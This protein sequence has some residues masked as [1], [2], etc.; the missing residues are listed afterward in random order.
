M[1]SI[2]GRGRGM[3]EIDLRFD[4]PE[5]YSVWGRRVLHP[6]NRAFKPSWLFYQFST[7]AVILLLGS[8]LVYA[9]IIGRAGF[10]SLVAGG[11]IGDFITI[12]KFKVLRKARE[13][14]VPKDLAFPKNLTL[15]EAGLHMV[16]SLE[17][18]K[19]SWRSV[20]NVSEEKH[21][22]SMWIGDNAIPVPDRL[23]PVGW[24]RAT[25]FAQV[26]A[27]RSEAAQ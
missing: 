12:Y 6:N 18:S 14:D 22:I 13:K 7:L 16:S 5:Q 25:L 21:G 10:L 2:I 15:D 24:S 17:D 4:S 27:W 26:E 20:G 3:G 11:I 9:S 23:L 8:F 1:G 19:L